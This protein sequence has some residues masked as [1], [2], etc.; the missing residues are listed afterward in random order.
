MVKVI[1]NATGYRPNLYPLIQDRPSPLFKVL[2]KAILIHIMEF[3]HDQDVSEVEVILCHMPAVIEEALGDGSRWGIR[4]HY[5]LVKKP[6]YASKMMKIIAKRWKGES[7]L[8]GWGDTLP[9]FT[10]ADFSSNGHD[11][12]QLLFSE[13]NTWHGW[14]LIPGKILEEIQ[15]DKEYEELIKEF[16]EYR[17]IR[18]ENLLT[19]ISFT[20]LQESNNRALNNH[21]AGIHPP[22]SA[23]EVSPGIWLSRATALHPQ[24]KLIAPVF[25]GEECQ[26]YEGTQIGPNTVIENHCIVD[27]NSVVDNSMVF[28]QSF[29]GVGLEL[30]H[31]IASQN[32][33]V[34]LLLNTH[35]QINEEFILCELAPFSMVQTLHDIIERFLAVVLAIL[36]TP[37]LLPLSL[38]YG[39]ETEE[40]LRLPASPNPNKK[41]HFGL[42]KLKIGEQEPFFIHHFRYLPSIFNIVKGD[43][44]FIGVNSI[45]DKELEELP[46]DWKKLYFNTKM[47]LI[48]LGD[49]EPPVDETGK[50]IADLYYSA[51]KSFIYDVKLFSR[52]CLVKIQHAFKRTLVRLRLRANEVKQEP[53]HSQPI[54][55]YLD[56]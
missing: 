9:S 45:T 7:I 18:K 53:T 48:T 52:W 49:V 55:A 14:G 29:V 2:D 11:I 22:S 46:N 35:I 17:S 19:A 54:K 6:F 37:L 12:P 34:N 3:L 23:H 8:V 13:D 1:L 10:L 50:T 15:A 32:T 33:V 36:A 24:A 30:R 39:I 26:I 21:A 41:E 40:K 28:S 43:L 27:K 20:D 5:N 42:Y 16:P 4:I 56:D 51:H 38:F 25:I 47:G 31:I 44:H